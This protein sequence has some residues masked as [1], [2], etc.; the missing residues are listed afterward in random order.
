V[1]A[2]PNRRA[3]VVL[4]VP[5]SPVDTKTFD[6]CTVDTPE[7][8]YIKARAILTPTS[9]EVRDRRQ[10]TLFTVE[11]PQTELE[12]RLF[13]YGDVTVRNMPGAC[14]CGGMRVIDKVSNA[15]PHEGDPSS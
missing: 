10:K 15:N 5:L 13:Q 14:G 7:R 4:A 1:P 9:L 8:T 3:F 6:V 12:R 2:D 11:L